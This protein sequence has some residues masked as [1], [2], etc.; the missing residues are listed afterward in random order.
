[1]LTSPVRAGE[2]IVVVASR[3]G[4]TGTPTGCATCSAAAR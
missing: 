3:G 4:E 2:A 1:M